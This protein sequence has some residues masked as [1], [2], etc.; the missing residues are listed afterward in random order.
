MATNMTAH[1]AAKV[2]GISV[3][4][5]AGIIKRAYA[6]L[7]RQHHPDK[8]GDKVSLFLSPHA[9][10]WMGVERFGAFLAWHGFT[11]SNTV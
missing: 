1:Q 9:W 8:G 7:A 11:P 2:L 3:D 5:S 4:S 10:I 6:K